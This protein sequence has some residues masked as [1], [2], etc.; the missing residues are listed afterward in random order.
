M[1]LKI[2]TNQICI[3]GIYIFFLVFIHCFKNT[4]NI[5]FNLSNFL[6]FKISKLKIHIKNIDIMYTYIVKCFDNL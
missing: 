6:K 3:Y 2:N 1:I 5:R 4:F